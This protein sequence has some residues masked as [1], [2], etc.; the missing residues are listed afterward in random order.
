MEW[1]D[2]DVPFAGG[3]QEKINPHTL[4]V[5]HLNR[6][7]NAYFAKQGMLRKRRGM[8]ALNKTTI[9]TSP[10][11]ISAAKNLVASNDELLLYDGSKVYG[12]SGQYDRWS[13]LGTAYSV[14]LSARPVLN[15][16]SGVIVQVDRTQ[17]NGVI[18]YVYALRVAASTYEIRLLVTDEATG[19][20]IRHRSISTANSPF[21]PRAVSR[22]N[23]AYVFW[24]ETSG[25]F[26][27]K[28]SRFDTTSAA[29][30]ATD[31]STPPTTSVATD[32]DANVKYDVATNSTYGVFIAYR[33]NVANTGKFGFVNTS[34]AL[35]STGTWTGGTITEIAVAVQSG[36]A[37]HGIAWI[38]SASG[39]TNPKAAIR[40]WDGAVWTAT[41]TTAVGMDTL[42]GTPQRVY[43][44]WESSQTFGVWTDY[45]SGTVNNQVRE[46]TLETSGAVTGNIARKLHTIS[47]A[48]RPFF[49]GGTFFGVQTHTSALQDTHF[50]TRLSDTSV[51][52]RILPGS[53]IDTGLPPSGVSLRAD[54]TYAFACTSGT[55]DGTEIS[56]YEVTL[57]FATRDAYHA[58]SD[59]G[60]SCMGGAMVTENDSVSQY[61]TGFLLYP[62]L[63]QYTLTPGAGGSLNGSGGTVTYSYKCYFEWTDTRGRKHRSTCGGARTVSLT[64]AQNR[65]SFTN[66]TTLAHTSKAA[67]RTNVEI[68]L[69]RTVQNPPSDAPFYRVTSDN[70][71]ATG[72]NGALLNDPA[73]D[74]VSFVDDMSDATLITKEQ[75]YQN[76]G[77][78]DNLAPPGG[79][80]ICAGKQ[81]VFVVNP[82]RPGEIWFSKLRV[83]GEALAFNDAFTI[84]VPDEG[85]PI[86]GLGVVN[87]S[88]C[89]FKENRI[90]RV[91]GDGPNNLGLGEF[92]DPELITSDVGCI[93]Q[94]SIVLTPAGLFFQSLKGIYLLDQ[95]W[96]SS[97]IGAPVEDK[98]GN[99]VLGINY[100]TGATLVS[101]QH[102]VR[103]LLSATNYTP[104]YDYLMGQWSLYTG[105]PGA[106]GG[107]GS[108]LS[109]DTYYVV[110]SAGQVS[111]ESST[112]FQN[113]G[114]DYNVIAETAW[115]K[116]ELQGWQRVRR[117]SLLGT[118]RNTSA[119]VNVFVYYDYAQGGAFEQ[120]SKAFTG[121]IGDPAQF[122]TGK[123]KKMKCQAIRFQ[124]Q[125]NG[126]DSLEMDLT[127][128]SLNVAGKGGLARLQ[129]SQTVQGS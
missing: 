49:V 44:L 20:V 69:Y 81:R 29:T 71:T 27:I 105:V 18:F 60:T 93:T 90:Y 75:D 78:V 30:L 72:S 56:I 89:I 54:G 97:Y 34:G 92:S 76:S 84:L 14:A 58:V 95:A 55:H 85:G 9:A 26:A 117:A 98:V 16:T 4:P 33:Q 39:V 5:A 43:C 108:C 114:V 70:P 68:V 15:A 13:D 124:V 107:N 126:A 38:D 116:P 102:Q 10:A 115:I 57:G 111:R 73:A 36:L 88:L 17:V 118:L 128:L 28:C 64:S 41:A 96:Q 127:G 2:V 8:D 23:I 45:G 101:E 67:P 46:H 25:T 113:R 129:A 32:V 11:T 19:S 122:R 91:T 1:T 21:R 61:E 99:A 79:H 35:G 3:V 109:R 110:D 53:A 103:F 52:G 94:R 66:I 37:L 125:L 120:W 47:M 83:S 87:E 48:C 42:G 100:V 22:G 112:S 24:Q 6:L 74:T 121:S 12:H 62:E 63:S 65:V 7:E 59:G 80:V 104:V 31:L 40:S 82:E 123:L 119:T 50:L 77:E 86:T 51:I 106:T